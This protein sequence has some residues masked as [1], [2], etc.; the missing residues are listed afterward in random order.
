MNELE[1]IENIDVNLES[2]LLQL[3]QIEYNKKGLEKLVNLIKKKYENIVFNEEDVRSAK[4]DKSKINN[5]IKALARYRIDTI[6]M[7][8]KPLEEFESTYKQAESELKVILNNMENQIKIFE[9]KWEK[10]TISKL[11]ELRVEVFSTI[12]NQKELIEYV[13]LPE[14][15]GDFSRSKF[16]LEKA[17]EFLLEQTNQIMNNYKLICSLCDSYN[18]SYK[19]NLGVKNY[20]KYINN[21]YEASKLIDEDRDRILEFRKQEEEKAKEIIEKAN[22]K[23]EEKRQEINQKMEEIE[24]QNTNT[25][26]KIDKKEFA[27]QLLIKLRKEEIEKAKKLKEFLD[28]EE[29]IYQKL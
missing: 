28:S 19:I 3:P 17:R 4:A 13:A 10:E 8:K 12:S 29:I 16:N 15:K 11:E 21:T 1:V 7:A 24:K 18:K 23:I 2:K 27:V 5:T 14:L 6:N 22:K 9:E 25:L 26:P 20:I